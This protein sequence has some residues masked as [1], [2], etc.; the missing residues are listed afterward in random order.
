MEKEIANAYDVTV[1]IHQ[2][3]ETA[4]VNKN[5]FLAGNQSKEKCN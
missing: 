1:D 5:R 3:N 4:K 2:S